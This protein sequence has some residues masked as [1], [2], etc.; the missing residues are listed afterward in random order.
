MVRDETSQTELTILRERQ[1]RLNEASLHLVAGLDFDEVLQVVADNARELTGAQVG[2]ITVLDESDD[3]EA[4]VVSGLTDDEIQRLSEVPHGLMFYEH[5]MG[6]SEPLRVPDFHMY[7]A[8]QGLPEFKPPMDV[9]QVMMA[10][11]GSRGDNTGAIY[12]SKSEQEPGFTDEDETTLVMFATQAAL[13]LANARRY[14]DEHRARVDLET[15]INTSP[16]GVMVLDAQLGEVTLANR[17]ALR[18]I[19]DLRVSDGLPLGRPDNI[20][21]HRA[22]GQQYALAEHSLV[23]LLR[24][25]ETIRAERIVLTR[26]G[27]PAIAVLVNASP[28][29]ATDGEITSVVVTL[30]DLTP[31]EDVDRLRADILGLASDE[32]RRPLVSI[33][34]S[35]VTLMTSH[36]TLD[37]DESLQLA[38]I[39]DA[40]ADRMRELIVDLRDMAR[41]H[42][43]TLSIDPGPTDLV[44]LVNDAADEFRS[45]AA[46]R[47]VR[48]DIE[49]ELVLVSA[50]QRH[51]ARVLRSILIDAFLMSDGTMPVI[52]TATRDSAFVRVSVTHCGTAPAARLA[53]LFDK[54]SQG[55][56][57][58]P[59][60]RVRRSELDLAISKGIVEAHGGRIWAASDDSTGETTVSFTV[61]RA[62]SLDTIARAG[63]ATPEGGL[64]SAN[65]VL[66]VSVDAPTQRYISSTLIAAGYDIAYAGDADE[67]LSAASAVRPDLIL[68]GFGQP[69]DADNI[70][71]VMRIDADI[72]VIFVIEYGFDEAV[73][74]AL[75]SG[76][77]DYIVKPFA[78][79]ELA[80]RIRAALQRSMAP[81][82]LAPDPFTIGDLTLDFAKRT[83]TVAGRPAG[84]TETE[85]RLLCELATNPGAIL[86]NEQLMRRV[87]KSH[88]DS[89]AGPV[90]SAVKRLRRKLGDNARDPAYVITVPRV[91]YRI[92][93]LSEPA[94]AT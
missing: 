5:L 75:E 43:G 3:L 52:V 68:A 74:R 35:A 26:Q 2:G 65:R 30:Q 34:G 28:I 49:S 80:A 39:I 79:T 33:K 63:D 57:D 83:V 10:P 72:P 7:L 9:R 38:H 86:S 37:R 25:G 42:T 93:T 71:S 67:A 14:R 76:A 81:E 32:L 47:H 13:V 27:G 8:S 18:I 19:E 62:Q 66:V 11:I 1:R 90:R 6:L 12:V 85:Y 4:F 23:S 91:G 46:Q 21:I 29:R 31:L 73:L 56:P 50:D 41:I 89:P 84:L 53:G 70:T 88:S 61:P 22:S 44:R 16:V 64:N 77:A 40:E 55:R 20:T 15:L 54:R 92:G 94:I 82:H 17:E 45:D 36:A 51:V 87:W 59:D 48:V 78:P 24:S 60:S 58:E 69:G